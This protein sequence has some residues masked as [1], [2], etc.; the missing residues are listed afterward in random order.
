MSTIKIEGSIGQPI[1]E[2]PDQHQDAA[3]CHRFTTLMVQ[4]LSKRAGSLLPE[5]ASYGHTQ[6]YRVVGGRAKGV[7]CELSTWQGEVHLKVKVPQYALYKTL[8]ELAGWLTA[9]LSDLGRP[10]ILEVE[11][12][13]HP[14]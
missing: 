2:F 9:R 7:T 13:E 14:E 4:T 10:V 11:H 6:R 12:A 1:A 5:G 8:L 3:G